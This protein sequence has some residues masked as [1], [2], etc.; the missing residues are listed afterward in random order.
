M[1]AAGIEPAQDSNRAGT[2]AR[3]DVRGIGVNTVGARGRGRK[4]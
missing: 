4:L 3:S 1:E 2:R